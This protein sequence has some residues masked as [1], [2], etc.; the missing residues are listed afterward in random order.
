MYE[1]NKIAY[2]KI[3]CFI[4]AELLKL[5]CTDVTPLLA[6]HPL[7]TPLVPCVCDNSYKYFL[8]S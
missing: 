6:S 2:Q 5:F 7:E 1:Q 4:Y 8:L 3:I